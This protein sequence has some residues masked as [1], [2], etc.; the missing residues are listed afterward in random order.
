MKAL[1]SLLHHFTLSRRKLGQSFSIIAQ[2]V[3]VL[4]AALFKRERGLN[5]GSKLLIIKR[6]FQEI[7][8][9]RLK[10]RACSGH[11]AMRSNHNDWQRA[12]ARK[13]FL[14]KL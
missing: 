1:C 10:S 5:R 3:G 13:Q 4:D 8:C 2:L 6:F 9:L 7:Y 11:V 12:T 14:L